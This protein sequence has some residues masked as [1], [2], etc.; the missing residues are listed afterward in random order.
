MTDMRQEF[1][2]W[3]VNSQVPISH[4]ESCREAWQ[5]ASLKVRKM[6]QRLQENQ[7]AFSRLAMLLGNPTLEA[8]ADSSLEMELVKLTVAQLA[9]L[10]DPQLCG[11][12]ARLMYS[13]NTVPSGTSCALCD[14]TKAEAQLKGMRGFVVNILDNLESQITQTD[15]ALSIAGGRTTGAAAITASAKLRIKV[16]REELAALAAAL[17]REDK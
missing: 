9:E 8:G 4:K 6:E 15:Q 17:P 7:A 1:E 14:L 5:A 13:L 16:W 3:L 10:S 12:P 2:K 11:H